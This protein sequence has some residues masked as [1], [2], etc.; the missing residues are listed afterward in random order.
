MIPIRRKTVMVVIAC[1]N[2][3]LYEKLLQRSGSY[4][5]DDYG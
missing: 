5:M 2:Q 1:G 3:K 4:A